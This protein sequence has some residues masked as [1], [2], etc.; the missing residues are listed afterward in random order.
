M[1]SS[2]SLYSVAELWS[3]AIKA[4]RLCYNGARK[5]GEDADM[6]A[7]VSRSEALRLLKI[8]H[9]AV[10]D[11]IA[12]LTDE[13]MTRGDTIKHGLYADQRCSFKDL[14]AHLVCYEAF[15]LAAIDDWREAR[16]HW[17]IEA[18]R[19]PAQSR[20]MH[21]GGISE[22]ADTSLAEQLAEYRTVSA[23][24]EAAIADLTDID[25]RSAPSF[26]LPREY[27]LGGMIESVMV[28]PPRPMYRHL[29]VHVPDTRQYIRRLRSSSGH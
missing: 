4:L 12:A 8:E 10:A 24:L 29:P 2:N 13:E 16:Q 1:S 21:Y 22:R 25:W 7:T 23:A 3:A 17:V 27:D 14:L 9:Q 26:Q 6:R 28:T 15:T 19:D 18:V 20:D 5:D 11:L